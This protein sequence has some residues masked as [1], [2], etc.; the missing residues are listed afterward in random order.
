MSPH[1]TGRGFVDNYGKLLPDSDIIEFQK[2]LDMKVRGRPEF[3][4][5]GAEVFRGACYFQVVKKTHCTP[6]SLS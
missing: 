2:I 1:E 3:T 6:Y 5:W 4:S